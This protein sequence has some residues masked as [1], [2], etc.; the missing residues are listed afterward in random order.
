MN[1]AL[2]AFRNQ[3]QLDLEDKF[4][5][6]I[7]LSNVDGA[8]TCAGGNVKRNDNELVSGGFLPDFDV[9]FRVRK[10]LLEVVPEVGIG[11]EFE[12]VNYRLSRVVNSPADVAYMLGAVDPRK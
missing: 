2:T 1:A 10:E 3:A 6:E 5:A 12:G 4:P 8:I 9:S 11:L 7:A